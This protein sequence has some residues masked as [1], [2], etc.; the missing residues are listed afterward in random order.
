MKHEYRGLEENTHRNYNTICANYATFCASTNIAPWPRSPRRRSSSESIGAFFRFTHY[1]VKLRH[2]VTSTYNLSTAIHQY[3]T[4]KNMTWVKNKLKEQRR[5][6]IHP[7]PFPPP[8]G[9]LPQWSPV[10]RCS[11]SAR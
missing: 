4:R 2:S 11:G 10:K 7:A 1:C 6:N 8:R 5:V 9:P 3:C